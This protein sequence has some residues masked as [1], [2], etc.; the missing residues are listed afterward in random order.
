MGQIVWNL[1]KALLQ[2]RLTSP[3]LFWDLLSLYSSTSRS[4][5]LIK[6]SAFATTRQTQIQQRP[7]QP[8]S[9]PAPTTTQTPAVKRPRFNMDLSQK[10]NS[11]IESPV[12]PP[13]KSRAGPQVLRQRQ[14]LPAATT[15]RPPTANFAQLA[16]ARAQ[17]TGSRTPS[18]QRKG[19]PVQIQQQQPQ[20]QQQ[21]D[22]D[23]DDNVQQQQQLQNFDDSPVQTSTA[24]YGRQQQPTG[25][26]Q[27]Q[28][29][30]GF[31]GVQQQQQIIQSGTGPEASSAITTQY[32]TLQPAGLGADSPYESALDDSAN[33]SDD[34]RSAGAKAAASQNQNWYIMRAI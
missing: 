3:P 27:R 30:Q 31:A 11:L 24:N 6:R 34:F 13:I 26:P 15:R 29:P 32:D 17:A 18:G 4:S 23:L 7:I 5:L 21:Y 28:A 22:S 12:R 16:V 33:S 25:G 8:A 20:Q 2:E 1:P 9:L 10:V 19:S 14:P